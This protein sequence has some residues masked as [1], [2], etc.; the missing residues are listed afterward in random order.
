MGVV[1]VQPATRVFLRTPNVPKKVVSKSEWLGIQERHNDHNEGHY[2]LEQK[3]ESLMIT[4]Y[5]R[6]CVVFVC[7]LRMCYSIVVSLPIPKQAYSHY[8]QKAGMR[9]MFPIYLPMSLS[10]HYSLQKKIKQ[11]VARKKILIQLHVIPAPHSFS[12]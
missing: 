1:N 11:F 4:A 8:H 9:C 10:E 12:N 2:S 6:Q 3:H 7:G 5:C